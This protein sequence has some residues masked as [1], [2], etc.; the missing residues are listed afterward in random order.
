MI[1]WQEIAVQ[2]GLSIEEFKVE[3]YTA[4]A[5]IA[6]MDLDKQEHRGDCIKFTCSD[7]VGK[8]ELYVRRVEE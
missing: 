8:L 1:D 4:A 5:A 6:A 2:N 7:E 3:L